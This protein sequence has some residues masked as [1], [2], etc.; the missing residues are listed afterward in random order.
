[1]GWIVDALNNVKNCC[2]NSFN[3]TKNKKEIR[4]TLPKLHHLHNELGHAQVGTLM[5]FSNLFFHK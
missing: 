5:P 4:I 2:N 1:M 3:K